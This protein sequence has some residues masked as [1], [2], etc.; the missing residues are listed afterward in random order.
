MPSRTE[1]FALYRAM[2]GIEIALRD[3][4]RENGFNT[5][6]RFHF[7]AVIMDKIG[8]ASFPTVAVE[9]GDLLPLTDDDLFGGS[10]AHTVG[11][12][13]FQW[14]AIV[15]GYVRTSEDKR[16]LYE[17]GTALLVDVFGALYESETLPVDGAGS[18]L[19]INPGDVVFDMESFAQN[20]LGYFA[21]EFRLVV[22]ITR[23]SNP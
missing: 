5:T 11:E 21:A 15:W 6:P 7:G 22:N 9:F 4:S 16:A 1:D 18:V 20:G 3:I 23:G 14:P 10:A 8:E 2:R 13:R 12:M 19:M 17:A